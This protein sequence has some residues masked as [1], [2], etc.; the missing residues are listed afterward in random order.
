M[1]R[2]QKTTGIAGLGIVLILLISAIFFFP[3]GQKKSDAEVRLQSAIISAA[4]RSPSK[5]WRSIYQARDYKP[6]WLV[7]GRPTADANAVMDLLA[8]AGDQGLPAARYRFNDPPPAKADDRTLAAF[9]VSLTRAATAY[10]HDMQLGMLKPARL[11]DDVSLPARQDDTLARFEQAVRDIN[12]IGYLKSLEPAGDYAALKSAFARYRELAAHPWGRV[13]AGDKAGLAA[14]LAA[15]GYIDAGAQ[16]A[17]KGLAPAEL[18]EALKAYQTANGLDADGKLDDRTL[19]MLNASPADRAQQ[20]AAN[21]ERWR[22]LPRELGARF[23]WVNVAGA[24][25][26]LVENGAPVLTSR[27]V[28]GAPD[29]PTPILGTEGIAITVNPVWHVPKSIVENEIEPKLADDPDYLDKKDMERTPEGDIIQHA[30]AQNALGTV[31]F[32]MPNSFDVYMHDTPSKRAF[33]SD[34][35]TLSHGCVRVEKISDLVQHVLQLPDNELSE[36]IAS[37]QTSRLP[38]KPPVPVYVLY[39][40]AV[41]GAPGRIGFRPDVYGRDARMIAALNRPASANLA[42]LK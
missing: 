34:E 41:P 24:S 14:R 10:A 26:V 38:I 9:D 30:G 40:T 2:A 39:W 6:L 1:T 33:L 19:A 16:T 4:E 27:V 21:M 13:Q 17:G 12:V 36:M 25:L 22:W 7:A 3:Q 42:S 20:I 35:R 28:V 15:E 18:D 31:K 23:I 29:K 32:E 37:G 11:F 8:H 5:S